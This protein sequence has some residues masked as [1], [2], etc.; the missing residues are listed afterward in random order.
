[1]TPALNTGSSD[2]DYVRVAGIPTYGIC[3]I[4]YDLDD[5][6][7]HAANERVSAR[8]FTEGIAYM[9][10]LMRALAKAMRPLP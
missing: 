9:A 10:A 7:M 1:M 2:S 5:D 6:R 3:S 8:F 4:F